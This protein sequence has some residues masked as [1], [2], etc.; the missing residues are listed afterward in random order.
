MSKRVEERIKVGDIKPGLRRVNLIVKIV[1]VG[2]PRTVTFRKDLSEHQVA[3]ALVGDETGSVLLT[4]WD[5]NIEK[6]S[7]GEVF[8]IK[9][10]YTSLFRGSLRLNIGFYGSA[11]SVEEAIEEVN[12]ENNLSEKSYEGAGYGYYRGYRGGG[13]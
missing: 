2:E 13:R 1:N 12:E 9:N 4:L 5:D 8:E 6:F 11:E 10:G 7:P 3:D